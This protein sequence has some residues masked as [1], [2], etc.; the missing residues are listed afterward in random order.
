MSA[1][2][3]CSSCARH[4][5][6]IETTCPFCDAVLPERHRVERTVGRVAS[7]AAL[8]FATATATAT[9]VAACAGAGPVAGYGPAPIPE[10]TTDA[11]TDGAK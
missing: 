3:V 8:V 5:R 10:A 6:A 1:L 9:A 7:R 11:G 2:F 4:V